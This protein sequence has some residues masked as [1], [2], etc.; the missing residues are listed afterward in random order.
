[1]QRFT[2]RLMGLDKDFCD[3]HR[4]F[5]FYNKMGNLSCVVCSKC[6]PR[7]ASA[8]RLSYSI[9]EARELALCDRGGTRCCI[10]IGNNLGTP[11]RWVAIF[12]KTC[13]SCLD[14]SS[15]TYAVCVKK[16]LLI[17][18]ISEA[19]LLPE[20]AQCIVGLLSLQRVICAD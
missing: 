13:T 9:A 4:L 8:T 7:F 12:G 20:L 5:I 10:C 19:H 1:M 16:V 2:E 17:R 3:V 6:F 11:W 15:L 18:A 14:R